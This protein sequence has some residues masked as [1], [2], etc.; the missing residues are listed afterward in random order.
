MSCEVEQNTI[1]Q[2]YVSSIK[3]H[4]YLLGNILAYMTV[5]V[6]VGYVI[7]G[8]NV[9]RA[10]VKTDFECHDNMLCE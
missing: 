10:R 4:E 1:L 9:T 8:R 3:A 2:V 7:A 5:V 6:V